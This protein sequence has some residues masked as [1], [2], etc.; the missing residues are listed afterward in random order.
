MKTVAISVGGELPGFTGNNDGSDT[1]AIG[2]V[3]R[4][5]GTVWSDPNRDGILDMG[6]RGQSRWIVDLVLNGVVVQLILTDASGSY[7]LESIASAASA[8]A[9]D[10]PASACSIFRSALA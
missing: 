2:G 9:L 5:S 10:Y 1:V 6:E 3:T 7:S 8:C 4:V